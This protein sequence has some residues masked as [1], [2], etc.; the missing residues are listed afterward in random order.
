[1][2][3]TTVEG[4]CRVIKGL[5]CDLAHEKREFARLL[6]D[7]NG[8]AQVACA[9]SPGP[10][11]RDEGITEKCPTCNGIGFVRPALGDRHPASS[12]VVLCQFAGQEIP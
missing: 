4:L 10:W 6:A 8:W 2:S 3:D 7:R 12:N 1:M 9:P 5:R 11:A